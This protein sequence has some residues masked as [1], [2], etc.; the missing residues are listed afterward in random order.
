MIFQLDFLNY[1]YSDSVVFLFFYF[2]VWKVNDQINDLVYSYGV[3]VSQ[4]TN[5]P[6]VI[7]TIRSFPHSW[8]TTEFATRVI[9]R[10]PPVEQEL[11][12]LREP[13]SSSPGFSSV[14]VVRSLVFCVIFCRTLLVFLS[15]FF[16][17]LYSFVYPFRFTD[18]HYPFGIFKYSLTRLFRFWY[19]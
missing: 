1:M 7:I 16:W 4:V 5:V 2:I 17:P 15:L 14:S 13:L 12:T 3:S 19:V 10:I 11:L 9:R 8:L 6:F 18:F